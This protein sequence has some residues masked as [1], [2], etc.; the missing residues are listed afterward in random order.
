MCSR[1]C[2]ESH[3]ECLVCKTQCPYD[4]VL[5]RF[6]AAERA[7]GLPVVDSEKCNGCGRCEDKC[8]IKGDSAITVTP[9][10]EIRLSAGSYVNECR[11]QGLTFEDKDEGRDTFEWKNGE[12]P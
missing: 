4:A 12:L 3:I 5:F 9:H 2:E 7:V 8:P 10:G 6:R 1:R 11:A